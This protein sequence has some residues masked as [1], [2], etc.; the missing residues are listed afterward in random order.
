MRPIMTRDELARHRVRTHGRDYSL[1]DD[2]YDD[3]VVANGRGWQEHSGWGRDGYDLG[4]WPFVI[5]F[6]KGLELL[7]T[8]EGDHTYYAF[9][10]A[11]DL[12]A[13]IDYLFVW[14]GM[15]REYAEWAIEGLT[16]DKRDALDAGLLRV[17][18][19]LRGPF[20]WARLEASK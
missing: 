2:G 20:S 7:T 6:T 14:Y 18:E 17:P 12:E 1:S 9:T 16:Y 5:V 19:H 4:D 13:A 11:D 15:G 8:C 3:M 10:S